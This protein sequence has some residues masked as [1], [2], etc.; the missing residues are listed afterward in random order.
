MA[1][2][3]VLE[4]GAGDGNRTHVTSL[5]GWGSTIELHPLLVSNRRLVYGYGLQSQVSFDKS[6]KKRL[7]PLRLIFRPSCALWPM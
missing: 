6:C 2:Q 1:F 4:D 5:E 3:R 7:A